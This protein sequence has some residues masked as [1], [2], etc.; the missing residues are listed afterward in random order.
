MFKKL[1]LAVALL[2]GTL[3]GSPL[4]AE[5]MTITAP[6][7]SVYDDGFRISDNGA[8]PLRV[9]AWALCGDRTREHISRGDII[10]VQGDREWRWLYATSIT[11]ADG[12][13]VCPEDAAPKYQ[14]N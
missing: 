7:L 3:S 12:T 4:K 8:L 2:V 5:E 6:A 1:P 11:K 9:D 14:M 13:P 10:T